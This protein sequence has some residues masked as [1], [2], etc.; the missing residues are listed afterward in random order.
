M[1]W[2]RHLFAPPVR[3]RFEAACMER[4]QTAIAASERTHRAEICFAVERALSLADLVDGVHSRERADAV[5]AQLRVWD[6][7]ANNGVLIYVLLA[8]HAIEIL[9]D[10]DVKM[11]IPHEEW[12]GICKRVARG[13]AEGRHA[14]AIV[15]G[16]EALTPLL[17]AHYPC[18]GGGPGHEASDHDELPDR[19]R[20]I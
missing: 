6:T 18:D 13:F 7:A 2:I 1:R 8:E 19:P 9:P 5:F 10:R 17:A 16:I 15:A 11:R 20:I 4:I 14:D 3:T 12:A